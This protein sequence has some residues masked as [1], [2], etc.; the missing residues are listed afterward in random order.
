MRIKLLE[1]LPYMDYE[2]FCLEL[3]GC[4]PEAHGIAGIPMAGTR[5]GG[6]V[7]FFP[8]KE[9]DAVMGRKYIED[10]HDR[11]KSKLSGAV[12]VVVPV[13]ACDP[14]LFEDVIRLGEN[15]Y[16]ILRVPYS[17]IEALHGRDF[18]VP[19]QPSSLAE[20]N[21]AL[22]SFGFDFVQPP[23][24]EVSYRRTQKAL[25]VAVGSFARGGLDPDDF[26]DQPDQGRR[27]LAMVMIDSNYDGQVFRLTNHLFG[28]DLREADWRFEIE[29]K[30]AGKEAM[31]SFMDTHGN[32]RREV[33]AMASPKRAPARKKA[34]KKTK[35]RAKKSPTQKPAKARA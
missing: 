18:Q 13:S 24:V 34:A 8:F 17:V 14:G 35:P 5:K 21:D 12:Y 11:L 31:L 10:L 19:P 16:F 28:D 9:V 22:D 6:P 25:K 15:V 26:A 33:V 30:G 27:D 7:H 3:F 1:H 2:Q 23:E 20:V 32:E 4:R 29:R